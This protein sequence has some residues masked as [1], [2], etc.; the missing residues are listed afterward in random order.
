MLPY[1]LKEKRKSSFSAVISPR[2]TRSRKAAVAINSSTYTTG[3]DSTDSTEAGVPSGEQQVSTMSF[4]NNIPP[5]SKPETKTSLE[6][7]IANLS[8]QFA[9]FDK[10]IKSMDD[11]IKAT[12]AEMNTNQTSISSQLNDI[13]NQNKLLEEKLSTANERIVTLENLYYDMYHKQERD[14]MNKQAMNLIIRGVPE[15]QNEKMHEIMGELLDIVGSF[16]YVNTNG[17]SRIG[18]NNKPKA[19]DQNASPRPIRLR[20]ATVLQKGEIFRAIDKLKKTDKF[21]EIRV[22]NELNKD[23]M[24][25]HKEVQMLYAE[26]LSI[27][28]TQVRMRGNRIEIDGHTYDRGQFNNLPKGI[29]RSTAST[30]ITDNAMAFQ[31]HCSVYSNLGLCN[32]S[33][34]LYNYVCVEQYMGYKKSKACSDDVAGAKILCEPNPYRIYQLTKDIEATQEWVKREHTVLKEGIRLKI[35]QNKQIQ[36]E[37]PNLKGKRIYEATY[38]RRYGAGFSLRDAHQGNFK[39]T[40]GYENRMGKIWEELIQELC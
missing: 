4:N 26:A 38:S 24:L 18:K 2:N 34:D 29:S 14:L 33:D 36:D 11:N 10:T 16:S 39:I 1:Q 32:F 31:G 17:A 20:C 7:M 12:R 5:P 30:V 3:A 40:Q 23:D 6:D 15:S 27:P 13:T 22:A 21:K 9:T 35:A 37:L 28:N 19:N 8:V 25:E